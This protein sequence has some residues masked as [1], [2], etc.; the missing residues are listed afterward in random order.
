[1]HPELFEVPFIHIAVK[2]YGLMMVL[3]FLTAVAIIR[4]LSRRFTPDPFLITNAALYS[5]IAGVLGARVF[6]VVHYW[7]Q[8]SGRP[9]K[10]FAIWE[11]GLELLGGVLLAITVILIY[12][13]RNKLPIRRYLD[14]LAIGLFAAL[15]LGRIG[16]FLNGCCYGKP[17]ASDWGIRF[18]YGSHPYRSQ[19]SPN[20]TRNRSEPYIQLPSDFFKYEL[21]NGGYYSQLKPFEELTDEQKQQVT[22]GPYR[23]L[24]LHPTQLY[25]SAAGVV[26][27]LIMYLFWKRYN[28]ADASK[29]SAGP[30]TKPGCT[31]ALLFLVYPPIRFSMEFLRD[32]NPFEHAWWAFY[33]GGTVS[34]NIAIWMFILGISL[35]IFFSLMKPDTAPDR[36]F[37]R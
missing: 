8:F 1:M 5:L 25:S 15:A 9:L 20:P 24:R 19:V 30:L 23:C 29:N 6:Y 11:G 7:E 34:Q 18:P 22:A 3:G 26:C 16:C 21:E 31:F 36:Q 33:K 35:M 4:R 28:R 10:V 13:W 14:V 27:S 32:D 17:T 12:L 2:S 37:K